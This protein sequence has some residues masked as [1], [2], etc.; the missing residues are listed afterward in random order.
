MRPLEGVTT[1][2]T[3]YIGTARITAKQES[4][5]SALKEQAAT[6]GISTPV[7]ISIEIDELEANLRAAYAGFDDF[8]I[9]QY[10][11]QLQDYREHQ[12]VTGIYTDPSVLIK[13]DALITLLDIAGRWRPSRSAADGTKAESTSD[14]SRIRFAISSEDRKRPLLA[15]AGSA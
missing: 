1:M 12:A 2:S 3:N 14:K 9:E 7:H 13:I 4:R 8:V 6:Y 15:L 10:Q 11:Q 5:L